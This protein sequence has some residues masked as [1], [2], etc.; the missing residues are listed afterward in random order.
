MG[1]IRWFQSLTA[2]GLVLVLAGSSAAALQEGDTWRWRRFGLREGLPSEQINHVLLGDDETSWA[3]TPA[4]VA[5]FDDFRWRAVPNP[6]D[7]ALE[8]VHGL[9]SFAGGV[10]FVSGRALWHVDRERIAPL[11]ISHPDG[12]WDVNSVANRDG[13]LIVSLD[14]R[15]D[16]GR[17]VLVERTGDVST[18]V[19]APCNPGYS[20]LRGSAHGTAYVQ[21]DDAVYRWS[22]GRWRPFFPIAGSDAHRLVEP[23]DGSGLA[24]FRFPAAARGLW[25]WPPGGQPEHLEEGRGDWVRAIA[26]RGNEEWVVAYDSG[27][28]REHKGGEWSN[29]REV[30]GRVG[31]VR[32]LC[33]LENGDLWMGT[34]RG[35]FLRRAVS[36]WTQA[37]PS[38]EHVNVVMRRANGDLWVGASDGLWVREG[39]GEFAHIDSILGQPIASI[40]ALAEDHE[41]NVWVG[42]GE[43]FEGALCYHDGEWRRFGKP[44]GLDAGMIHAIRLDASGG[45]WFLG[46]HPNPFAWIE[47]PGAARYDGKAFVLWDVPAGLPNGRVYDFAEGP[48]GAYWFGT[49]G[50][51][52]RFHE[53]DWSYWSEREGLRTNKIFALTVDPGGRVWFGHQRGGLGVLDGDDVRYYSVRDGLGGDDVWGVATD[54]RGWVW[55]TTHNGL[56]LF[57]DGALTSLGAETGLPNPRLWGVLPTEERVY[58]GTLGDGLAVLELGLIDRRPPEVDF[59]GTV[60]EGRNTVA[61][62]APRAP[63]VAVPSS[64]I[65]TRFRLDQG[66]WSEWDLS[67][68][69][70]LTE[71]EPGR[72][73]LEVQARGLLGDLSG[74]IALPAFETPLPYYRRAAFV[75][76]IAVLSASVLVLAGVL[77]A[78]RRRYSALRRERERLAD[79]VEN[80]HDLIYLHDPDG[81]LTS[82]NPAACEVFGL[83]REEFH[84]ANL[85]ELIAEDDRPRWRALM[86]ELRAG[87]RLRTYELEVVSRTGTHV[88]LEVSSRALAGDGASMSVQNVARDVTRRREL[89]SQLLQSQKMEAVGQ[90]AGGI[91]HDFNNMLLVINGYS[92]L[93]LQSLPEDDARR[94]RVEQIYRAGERAATL[95]RQLLAY[96]RKQVLRPEKLDLGGLV[97]DMGELL[98]RVLSE[99]IELTIAIEEGA[100]VVEADPVQLQQVVLNL[101]VNARDEMPQGGT[102]RIATARVQPAPGLDANGS[103]LVELSVTDTGGGMDEQTRERLFEPFFTTKEQ[104]RGTGL[105]LSTVYG[106]VEQSGGRIEVESERDRGTTFRI[107]LPLVGVRAIDEPDT[108]LTPHR[109]E[110]DRAAAIL[111]VEDESEVRSWLHDV[112]SEA[113]YEVLSAD[114]GEAALHMVEERRAPLDLLVT[115]VVMP[116][117][118]GPELARRLSARRAELEVLYVSGYTGEAL[119]SRGAGERGLHLLQKPF[120]RKDLLWKVRGILAAR[121]A[122]TEPSTVPG[123]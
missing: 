12:P 49:Y 9:V 101:V 22:E 122:S 111:L 121:Q 123:A 106:I 108:T 88:S 83:S 50:G 5:W 46:L 100:T 35:L 33:H 45:V 59:L 97:T 98:E 21:C 23:A 54:E 99:D 78:R 119:A 94:Q 73:R 63:G 68:E 32:S 118:S 103:E 66:P 81:G 10:V 70:A 3:F 71:L 114:G 4:G 34:E 116:G 15:E 42:S 76:P 39:E 91:A 64:E 47:G 28:L 38:E 52:A 87:K 31:H 89:E 67:A 27:R 57:R 69:A 26:V 17:Q 36:L 92:D 72:H 96:S 43:N 11:P 112:L 51:L 115:D 20:D 60:V 56:S 107:R 65:A 74:P 120:R 1:R 61:R 84:G 7:A 2:T 104:G 16:P 40:T 13:V 19:E 110:K 113:G 37:Y 44:D 105:G 53:G 58:V 82:L 86:A 79:L 85:E 14:H 77:Y 25:A 80:A 90:L 29:V 62:W 24:A 55:I 102:L 75:L 18:L 109:S 93:L 30:P 48:D 8:Q 95:T 41:G 117:M 6:N